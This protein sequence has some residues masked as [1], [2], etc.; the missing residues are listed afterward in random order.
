MSR[1]EP[2]SEVGE[3]I[4]VRRYADPFDH[5]VGLILGEAGA[6]VVDTRC[7]PAQARVLRE[8][9][10]QISQLPVGWVFNTHE[11]WDHV[12]GNQEFAQARIWGHLECRNRLVD[13]GEEIRTRVMG[14]YPDDPAYAEVTVTPP[15]DT[16]TDQ[17]SIDLGARTVELAF[18][19]LGHTSNDA[20]I[21]VDGVT[22]AGD[23]VEEGSAPSF[24][25]SFPIAW[26]ETI[27]LL[28]EAARPVVV[29]GHGAPVEP[30]FLAMSRFDL[31]W[32]VRTARTGIS[33]GMSIEELGLAGSPYPEEPARI[34]LGRAY[35]ELKFSQ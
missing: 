24:D 27:G 29:P 7:N 3:R 13:D 21:H 31:A 15:T 19:G 23:L 8:E 28:A 18:Y 25:D 11:H 16:F 30:D 1:L 33:K 10:R 22:F 32:I 14:Y 20:V 2:W 34:A 26:V 4:Y 35:S 9:I 12:F 5:N 6:L 17:A